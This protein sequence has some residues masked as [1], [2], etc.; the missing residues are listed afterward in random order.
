MKNKHLLKKISNIRVHNV[1][2]GIMLNRM[3]GF[4]E[5]YSCRTDQMETDYVLKQILEYYQM[6]LKEAG[7]PCRLPEAGKRQ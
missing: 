3:I 5:G 2:S 1:N 6:G 7:Q 4:L